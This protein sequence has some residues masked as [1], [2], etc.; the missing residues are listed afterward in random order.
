MKMFGSSLLIQSIGLWWAY[1]AF[2]KFH[3]PFAIISMYHQALLIWA[4]FCLFNDL[5]QAQPHIL[6]GHNLYAQAKPSQ[7]AGRPDRAGAGVRAPGHIRAQ[8]PV[9]WVGL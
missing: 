1:Q 8:T 3:M 5:I 7:K 2:Y 9:D 6:I 4:G